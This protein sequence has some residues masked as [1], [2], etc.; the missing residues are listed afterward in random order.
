MT[1]RF[2]I[3]DIPQ[4]KDKTSL[5]AYLE[6][7]LQIYIGGKLFFNQPYILL[8]ELAISIKEWL[9][10]A[11]GGNNVDYIYNTMD[12]DEPLLEMIH[13]KSGSFQIK[14]I[15]QD[16]EIIEQLPKEEI[17]NGFE[18]YLGN[19]SNTLKSKLDI[20]LNELPAEES[21]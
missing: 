9:N 8:I 13:L 7:V 20:D 18:E 16:L 19:L 5:I 12:H 4:K 21:N 3:T 6:G 15:W 2:E 14:S 10:S 17:I 1:F 11:E